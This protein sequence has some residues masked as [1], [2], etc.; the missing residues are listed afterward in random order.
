MIPPMTEIQPTKRTLK[1]IRYRP[2]RILQRRQYILRFEPIYLSPLIDKD[3]IER[4]DDETVGKG[5]CDGM[6]EM[7]GG[8]EHGFE[9]AGDA[10]Q[11]GENDGGGAEHC[12]AFGL[13]DDLCCAVFYH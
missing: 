11:G 1:P 9:E 12:G 8:T 3:I 6:H 2:K 4:K 13:V 10:L 5:S 7:Q